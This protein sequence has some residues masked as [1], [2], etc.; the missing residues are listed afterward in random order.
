MNTLENIPNY[1]RVHIN[2]ISERFAGVSAGVISPAI[3][4]A[5][6]LESNDTLAE[7][8]GAREDADRIAAQAHEQLY[9]HLPA[10]L[11]DTAA[12][13]RGACALLTLEVYGILKDLV[14]SNDPAGAK[15]AFDLLADKYVDLFTCKIAL[16]H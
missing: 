4:Q 13:L 16:L 6:D 5:C 10:D 1:V 14:Q 7:A 8:L 2:G 11:P 3:A 15:L 12:V 9:L